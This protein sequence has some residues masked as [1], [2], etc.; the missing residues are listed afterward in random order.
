[1]QSLKSSFIK[2]GPS[3]CIMATAMNN[4][5]DGG[6]TRIVSQILGILSKEN[7]SNRSK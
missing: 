2:V 5:N 7:M 4:G 6:E 1:M 3:C